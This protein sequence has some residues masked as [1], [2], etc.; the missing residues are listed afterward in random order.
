MEDKNSVTFDE[1]IFIPL[2]D[3]T[4]CSY[5]YFSGIYKFKNQD[6]IDFVAVIK[7]GENYCFYHDDILDPCE[8]DYIN[9]ENPSMVIYKKIS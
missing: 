9:L 7:K 1:N 3:G 2:F 8:N 6:T 4:I 5:Q